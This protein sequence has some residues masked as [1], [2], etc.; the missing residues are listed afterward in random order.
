MKQAYFLPPKQ[1]G[2]ISLLMTAV[3]MMGIALIGISCLYY[4]RFSQWPMQASFSRWSQ[5]L[6]IIEKEV[7]KSAGLVSNGDNPVPFGDGLRKCKINGKIVY[8]NVDCLD[9]NATTRAVQLQDNRGFSSPPSPP[10]DSGLTV[11]S[12]PT[13]QEKMISKATDKAAK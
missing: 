13:L 9:S 11:N 5:S 12:G 2:G 1:S 7:K 8:S 4:L 3:L 6:G 10:K